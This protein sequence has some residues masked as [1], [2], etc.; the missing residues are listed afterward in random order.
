MKMVKIIRTMSAVN[1]E[2]LQVLL[3]KAILDETIPFL[4]I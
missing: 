4:S 2:R 1:H 3:S